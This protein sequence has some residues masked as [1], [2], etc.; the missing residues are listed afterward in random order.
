MLRSASLKQT[1][2][3]DVVLSDAKLQRSSES[4]RGEARLSISDQFGTESSIGNRPEM[5]EGL[6][7][8]FVFRCSALLNSPQERIRLVG[9]DSAICEIEF[10]LFVR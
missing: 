10:F 3:P 8:C 5:F 6:A 1:S 7:L 4:F 2:K 9:H